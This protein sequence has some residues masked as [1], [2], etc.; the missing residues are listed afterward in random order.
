MAGVPP[1]RIEAGD[2]LLGEDHDFVV[3]LYLAVLRRWPDPAGYRHYMEM[4]ANRPERRVE[5]MRLMAA[6]EE[7]RRAGPA[8]EIGPDPVLPSDPRRALAAVLALRTGWLQEQ[9]AAVREAVELLGGPGGPELAGLGAELVEAREAALR[10]EINALR[11]E[12]TERL[13]AVLELLRQQGVPVASAP[14]PATPEERAAEAV[15]RLVADYVGDLLA[16]TEARFEAR[17]RRIEAR[18]L[19]QDRAAKPEA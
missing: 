3:N 11:R 13:E 19:A 14:R 2:L 1:R 18:L 9:V 6:S 15:S 10:S 5:A 17:L 12:M 16:L 7:A 8:L 4:I